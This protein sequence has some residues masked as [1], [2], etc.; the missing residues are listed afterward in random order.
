MK[1]FRIIVFKVMLCL[2]PV[3]ISAQDITSKK[4]SLSACIQI[5]LKN[6]VDVQKST[7]Q[8]EHA[9]IN[10]LQSRENILPVLN[11]NILHGMNEG[12]SIDPY[13][14]SYINQQISYGN[15]DISSSLLL[16]NGLALQSMMQQSNFALKAT[17]AQEQLVKDNLS[18][19]VILI[20][21][22]VLTNKDLLT[23]LSAQKETTQ[24]QL[25]RSEILYNKGSIA[26]AI[27]YDLKG[28]LMNDEL[29]VLNAKNTLENSKI[30][31]SQLLNQP[32]DKQMELEEIEIDP[33][34][35]NYDVNP[36]ELYKTAEQNL[37]LVKAADLNVKRTAMQIRYAR[38]GYYPSVYL[39]G[40]LYSNFSS[41][42][43]DAQN[44]SINYLDQVSNNLGKSLNVGVAIP[45]FNNLRTRN[46][47]S[48]AKLAHLESQFIAEAT[49][50]QLQQLTEQAYLNMITAK[51]RCSILQEQVNAFS[52]SFKT[53]DVRFNLGVINSVDYLVSKNN[54]EKTKVNLV[55]SRYD[56]ILRKKI[57]AFYEG[58]L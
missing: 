23:L 17:R 28:Q 18:L 25:E 55:S 7:I 57:V 43:Y 24:K 9:R 22:Q 27:Y 3:C 5:A 37:A 2:F 29:L 56:F 21:L 11:A 54:L 52:E 53:A 30:T 8:T 4:L 40:G 6:N 41:A 45:L 15:Q 49:R 51:E 20:Y 47:V 50:K 46:N 32:Y 33:S 44:R 42:A 34:G 26:P 13:T 10:L 48:K 14:N 58:K 38:S 1:N 36:E 35:F 31:L 19:N 16:F 12:R 39:R